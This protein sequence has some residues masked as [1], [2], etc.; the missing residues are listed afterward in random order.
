MEQ[1]LGISRCRLC[2]CN[3]GSKEIIIKGPNGI[4]FKIPEGFLHYVKHHNIHISQ[5]FIEFL[6]LQ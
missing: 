1:Y 6:G 5:Q 2:K 4:I 3:N